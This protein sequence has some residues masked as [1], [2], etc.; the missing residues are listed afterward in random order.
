MMATSN[1]FTNP[2]ALIE[3][4]RR[5]GKADCVEAQTKTAAL[6][7]RTEPWLKTSE[8]AGVPDYSDLRQ[9]RS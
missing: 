8:I 3:L 4:A 6:G 7:K 5:Q 1:F 2:H 9:R